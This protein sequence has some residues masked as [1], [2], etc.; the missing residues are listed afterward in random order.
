MFYP[1]KNFNFSLKWSDWN[2]INQ[3]QA[4]RYRAMVSLAVKTEKLRKIHF[5][6]K[7]IMEFF[8]VVHVTEIIFWLQLLN[9]MKFTIKV[10][11]GWW[12]LELAEETM[13]LF[14]NTHEL[15]NSWFSRD[16]RKKLK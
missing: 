6:V 14:K 11:M 8:F 5:S 16:V 3:Y 9:G 4:V 1:K 15:M 13:G 10:Y 7:D 2:Y 12:I